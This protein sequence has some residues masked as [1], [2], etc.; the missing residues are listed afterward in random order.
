M[1]RA[2]SG[3]DPQACH[4]QALVHKEGHA[5]QKMPRQHEQGILILLEFKE[6][7]VGTQM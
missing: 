4:R 3:T 7:K 1:I 6:T 2:L 5:A